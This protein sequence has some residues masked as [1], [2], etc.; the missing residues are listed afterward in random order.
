MIG[1]MHFKALKNIVCLSFIYSI[2]SQENN[3]FNRFTGN[4]D[5]YSLVNSHNDFCSEGN[6]LNHKI[7]I[8]LI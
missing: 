4:Q 2:L 6:I 5:A 8:I 7:K 1:T 3:N